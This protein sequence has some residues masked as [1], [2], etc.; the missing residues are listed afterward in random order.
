VQAVATVLAAAI[1]LLGAVL[2][3]LDRI[4]RLGLVPIAVTPA[5][6]A[7]ATVSRRAAEI[8]PA[9]GPSRARPS[10]AP[11]DPIQRSLAQPPARPSDSPSPQP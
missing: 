11:P 6:R 4:T 1:V 10:R 3:V 9:D 5:A 2:L 7:A 8:R